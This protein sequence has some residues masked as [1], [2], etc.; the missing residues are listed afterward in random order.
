M[1]HMS[2][3]TCQVSCVRCHMSGVRYHVSSGTCQVSH[4]KCQVSHVTCHIYIFV[5]LGG[6]QNVTASW[7]R[8]CYKDGKRLETMRRSRLIRPTIFDWI[9]E[10]QSGKKILP[11]SA[12][13][14]IL[15]LV[16]HVFYAR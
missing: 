2:G 12:K 7:W 13:T 15:V 10:D 5:F 6:G 9:R 14:G 16:G 3:V 4:V 11:E 8:V 1:C